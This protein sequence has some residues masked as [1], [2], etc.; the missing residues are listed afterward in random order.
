MG[1]EKG[2]RNFR[3]KTIYANFIAGVPKHHV[4]ATEIADVMQRENNMIL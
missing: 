4:E 1:N 2:L 3:Q